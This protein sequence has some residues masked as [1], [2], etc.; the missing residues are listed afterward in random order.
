[1]TEL[2]Y[3]PYS[4]IF[5]MMTDAEL[6][7]LAA[8][9]KQHGQRTPIYL[10]DWQILDGRN[11]YRACQIAGVEPKTVAYRDD[12]NALEFVISSNLHRRHLNES[13]RAMVAAKI[14][15]LKGNAHGG[16][17]EKGKQKANLPLAS[18]AA[19][20]NVSPRTVKTAAAVLED[21]PKR[22]VE[23]VERG[24][25][26]V[27]AVVREQKEKAEAAEEILD[28]N[29]RVVP[30]CISEEFRR[31]KSVSEDLVKQLRA[32][33]LAVKRGKNADDN[34]FCEITNVTLSEMEA[35]EYRMAQIAPFAVCPHCQ[36]RGFKS[37]DKCGKRGFVSKFKWGQQPA[38]LR[39]M[40][41]KAG[42]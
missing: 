30:F 1:M 37:C 34:I 39:E 38:H 2:K 9:I 20:V 17:R 8:D 32:V 12:A 3:H 11:R 18:A 40:A 31:A 10:L 24:E 25:K 4:E 26:S 16:A 22:E 19:A 42:K 5:P 28:S 33:R 13:Q 27:S 14:L 23:K 15:A 35:M 21:A 7:E 41:L 6:A 29:G 36:G